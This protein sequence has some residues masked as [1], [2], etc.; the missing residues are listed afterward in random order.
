MKIQLSTIC[1]L[2]FLLTASLILF[3][4]SSA[5]QTQQPIGTVGVQDATVAGALEIT[6]GRAVLVGSTTVTAHDR[7]AE[8]ALSRGGSVRV[9]ATSGLHIA[10][11][12]GAA[13]EVDGKQP[14]MFAL[15]R[16]AIE[17]K[18]AATTRDVVMT[19]DLRFTMDGDGPLD[20][21]LRVT[22]NGDTCVENRGALAPV[23]HVAD[24]F[25]QGTYELRAG[26]HV[27]FEH[28]S[29]KEVV[30]HETSS[31]GCPPEPV[32]AP[33]MSVADA[34]VNPG[35]VGGAEGKAAEG[36]ATAAKT[37]EE[38]HPFPAAVSEGLAPAAAVP[39]APAGE[40]HSQVSA[41]LNSGDV[42]DSTTEPRPSSSTA[43]GSATA[44]AAP[45][46]T[47][48]TAAASATTQPATVHHK[49]V[50]RTVGRFFR[51]IFGPA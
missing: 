42:P 12:S 28:A 19:P 11:G 48:T 1:R 3:A 33:S 18:M 23:L 47:P 7:V 16:G 40:L 13:S 2:S 36:K 31:C 44:G 41:T 20:L 21:N 15:D 50:F 10:E 22:K 38:Q 6:N 34:L 51:R 43:A 17:V 9:C 45:A 39:K 24:P 25:G 49:G 8:V 30:D 4:R 37:A 29:L 26:Q 46:A 5:A 35:A 14:L 32:A 27:L